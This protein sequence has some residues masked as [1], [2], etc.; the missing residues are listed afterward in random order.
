MNPTMGF[1]GRE[2]EREREGGRK[3]EREGGEGREREGGGGRGGEGGGE[4]GGCGVRPRWELGSVE[5]APRFDP[6]MPT[7]NKKQRQRELE[8]ERGRDPRGRGGGAKDR[9]VFRGASSSLRRPSLS[10]LPQPTHKQTGGCKSIYIHD[11]K[12]SEEK[13]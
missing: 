9:C 1:R 3:R 7:K 12:R 2:R 13:I 11:V 10:R 6:E 8:R 4:I 5:W